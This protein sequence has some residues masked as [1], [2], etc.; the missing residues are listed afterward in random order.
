MYECLSP[1][2]SRNAQPLCHAICQPCWGAGRPAG[3]RPGGLA[4]PLPGGRS[5]RDLSI[6][7][8][9]FFLQISPYRPAVRFRPPGSGA[10]G[11][12]SC[13]FRT[14]KYIFVKNENKKY[15]KKNRHR[16]RFSGLDRA[17]AVSGRVRRVSSSSCTSWALK[18]TLLIRFRL[19]TS[20]YPCA[21]TTTSHVEHVASYLSNS[22]SD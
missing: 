10:A 16:Q 4:A 9:R 6:I 22:K 21:I 7:F 5:S 1:V 11:V 15:N 19:A 20:K 13:K 8:C 3:G 12:Y 18:T 17:P 2:S 14:R